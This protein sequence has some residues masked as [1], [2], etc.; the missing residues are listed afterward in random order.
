MKKGSGE[1]PSTIRSAV[2]GSGQQQWL[3]QTRGGAETESAA[4]EETDGREQG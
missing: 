4:A 2:F 1:H 3:L